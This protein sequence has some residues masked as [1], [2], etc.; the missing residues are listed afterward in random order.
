[1]G[2]YHVDWDWYVTDAG[3]AVA[4][5]KT[6]N[7]WTAEFA[8]PWSV[9]GYVGVDGDYLPF[10][11]EILSSNS[12]GVKR[13]NERERERERERGGAMERWRNQQ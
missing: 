3:T 10:D 12:I 11:I 6:S 13:E 7:G 1:M 4:L 9:L 8:L 5:N 2:T